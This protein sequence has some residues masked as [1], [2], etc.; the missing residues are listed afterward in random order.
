MSSLVKEY[1]TPMYH[2]QDAGA[3][4]EK[5]RSTGKREKKRTGW[6]GVG[7]GDEE[8]GGGEGVKEG[9][10]NWVECGGKSGT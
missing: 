8:E 10:W 3:E 2:E 4:R 9:E 5:R 1:V 6:K 7:K